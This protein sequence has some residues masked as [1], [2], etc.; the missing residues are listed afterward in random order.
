MNCSPGLK[1]VIPDLNID[2]STTYFNLQRLAPHYD[3]IL[4]T[5]LVGFNNAANATWWFGYKQ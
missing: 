3:F 2:I 4:Q 5:K 1:P